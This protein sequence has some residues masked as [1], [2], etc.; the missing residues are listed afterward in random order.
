MDRTCSTHVYGREERCAQGFGG[1]HEGERALGRSK[2]RWEADI[3][4]DLQE[5]GWRG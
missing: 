1:K 3:K 2:H 5:L 4:M